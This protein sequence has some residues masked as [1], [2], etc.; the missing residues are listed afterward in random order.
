MFADA[1]RSHRG[2]FSR[3]QYSESYTP[4]DPCGAALPE[5]YPPPDAEPPDEHRPEGMNYAFCVPEAAASPPRRPIRPRSSRV[6][7]APGAGMRSNRALPAS[8]PSSN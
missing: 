3:P 8:V 7:A 4:A 2:A 5:A 1:T 6:V